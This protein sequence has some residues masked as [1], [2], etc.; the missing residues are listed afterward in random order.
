MPNLCS[1]LAACVLA[2]APAFA[3]FDVKRSV[4]MDAN[5]DGV[6]DVVVATLRNVYT[7]YGLG[8]GRFDIGHRLASG[9]VG[10]STL[11]LFRTVV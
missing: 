9:Y 2:T 6:P 3:E 1:V 11:D 8:K 5:Q 4:V 10:T 7:F